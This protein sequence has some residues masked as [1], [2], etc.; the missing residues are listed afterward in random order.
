M[1]NSNAVWEGEASRYDQTR[2]TPPSAL[3][4]ILTQLI[5]TPRPAL[6]VDLGCGTGL[7]TF[8]WGQRAEHVIGIEPSEDMLTQARMK[9]KT[10][11]HT[12]QITF[13]KGTADQTPLPGGSV[14]IVTCAQA[15]HWM[16]PSATLAEIARILRPGG[17]FA[18]YDYGWPP[19][20]SWELEQVF[21]EVD[22][23]FEHLIQERGTG[24]EGPGW[25]KEQHLE[26][27]RASGHFRFTNEFVLQHREQGDAARF[28]GLVLSSGYSYQLKRGAVTEQEIGLDRLRQAALNY[29]GPEPVPW[30]FGYRVRLGVR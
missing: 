16:E 15:F 29:V 30:Y 27:M 7:S 25:S 1:T 9:L 13:Q 21:Q 6:V 5:H 14:D 3:I 23:R 10:H 20:I 4:E 28:I 19:T 8:I 22:D 26:R 11:P 17:I 18:A 24:G 12:Q 2:P